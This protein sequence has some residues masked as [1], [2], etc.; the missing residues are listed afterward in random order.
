MRSRFGGPGWLAGMTASVAMLAAAGG[1][2]RAEKVDTEL[3][4][5]TVLAGSVTLAD[6]EE[7]SNV[8]V[9]ARLRDD[10]AVTD[11]ASTGLD[12]RFRIV[13][14]PPGEYDVDATKE[15]Y[16]TET[17]FAQLDEGL[18]SELDFELE[19]KP[20]GVPSSI[21]YISGGSNDGDPEQTGAVG[22]RL[23]EPFVV[24]VRD[25]ADEPLS[26][27][28]VIFQIPEDRD[29]GQMEV[30][31]WMSSDVDG[32]V[33]NHY[34]LGRRVGR[35]R[36]RVQALGLQ[37]E[38]VDFTARG[39]PGPAHTIVLE[40]GGGQAALVGQPLA[41]PIAVR[42]EDEHANP[43]PDVAVRFSPADDG[44]ADPALATSDEAGRTQTSWTLGTHAGPGS[45]AQNLT[46]TAGAAEALVVEATIDHGPADRL[47]IASG[48]NQTTRLNSTA[49][50]PLVVRLE[51]G[52]G[53]PVD[54][55]GIAWTVVAG[56]CD[57]TPPADEVQLTDINGQVAVE[58]LPRDTAAYQSLVE[59]RATAGALDPVTFTIA[60]ISGEP[61][62][63]RASGGQNQ[64]GAIGE[65]LSDSLVFRLV[66]AESQPVAGAFVH[67][68]AGADHGA[69]ATL[70]A[71]EATTDL[72]GHVSVAMT[73]GTAA[74][75]AAQW[76]TASVPSF[77]GV[78]PA[79]ISANVFPDPPASMDI[80]SGN[81]QSQAVGEPLQEPLVLAV[82]DGYGN[83]VPEIEVD[84]SSTTGGSV[85]PNPDQTD[86]AGQVSGSATMGSDGEQQTQLFTASAAGLEVT[87][88]ATAAGHFMDQIVPAAVPPGHP[89][90]ADPSPETTP[91]Q[92]QILGGGFEP[93]A[94][95][96]WDYG[97]AEEEITADTVSATAIEFT[98]MADRFVPGMEGTYLVA[99]R[100]PDGVVCAP[101]PFAV[102][103]SVP[104]SGQ[105]DEQCTTYE[106]DGEWEWLVVDCVSIQP[107]ADYHGQD[108][109]YHAVH[110]Q[111]A[112]TV[113][114]DGT[115]T[116]GLTQLMWTRCAAGQDPINCS[117]S[118]DFVDHAE[119]VAYCQGLELAGHDD[120]FL[121]TIVE[122]QHIADYGQLNYAIDPAVYP[123]VPEE[124]FWSATSGQED[125]DNLAFR[126][127]LMQGRTETHDRGLGDG[128]VRC[129]RNRRSPPPNRFLRSE[130]Q[131]D[132]PVVTDGCSGLI[133]QGC[134]AGSRG[135]ACDQGD[136][137]SYLWAD[138]LAY[139]QGLQWAG[140]DDWR[141]PQ[142]KEL[143]TIVDFDRYWPA[144]DPEIFPGTGTGWYFTATSI[145][146][147]FS[148]AAYAVFLGE[149]MVGSSFKDWDNEVF[150]VR[151]DF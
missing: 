60:I 6:G 21:F 130:P 47:V 115:V 128:V 13:G 114:G 28:Q 70:D 95:V 76:V 35:N 16:F 30:A 140:H 61:T 93:G 73:L 104:D 29:G 54:Q 87:F 9:V 126:W 147:Q 111:P 49:P 78:A 7:P 25:A 57:L 144:L 113:N 107:G 81:F 11:S 143:L 136:R 149:G 43:V 59:I 51:D 8:G 44:Q 12:G 127:T 110:N 74:G 62:A 133:W 145:I 75:T 69:L 146:N 53:N 137:E 135:F 52:Y 2:Q 92:I 58:A 26:D 71:Y 151:S 103:F 118:P 15:G 102:T 38:H 148:D 50:E 134:P 77:P 37:D 4:R 56:S 89:D 27:V 68:A 99:V 36:I 32:R 33:R 39:L 42:I 63:L 150:C 123:N 129:V 120:W 22:T 40:G 31:G 142:I 80:V 86:A 124:G 138:A 141:L 65:T 105:S 97:A 91:V 64:W 10:A 88:T 108:G 17:K 109:H 84:W 18:V 85:T 5:Q 48:N 24:E 55:V 112:F 66:D 19:R 125:P 100:N 90:P 116:D 1:C 131:P 101:L 45:I 106:Y 83:P 20:T 117:G 79:T 122:L 23:A 34:L 67:F 132:E 72:N 94:V 121:P 82:A 139:C 46:V 119:A 14:L 98:L 3:G 41:E 96:L